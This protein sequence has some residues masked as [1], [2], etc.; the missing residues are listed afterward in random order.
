MGRSNKAARQ[1]NSRLNRRER[2]ASRPPSVRDT[3]IPRVD[4]SQLVMP[5]GRCTRNPRRPKDI[6]LTEEKA[7]RALV[8]AQQTRARMGSGH[9][10]KRYYR[11]EASE[12]GCGGHHLTSRDEYDPNLRRTP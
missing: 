6:F 3:L 7:R 8:Q 9:M 4:V 2:G 5:D 10:E 12:G 11:C 1:R